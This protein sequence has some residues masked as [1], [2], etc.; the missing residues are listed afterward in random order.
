MKVGISG[1]GG[2]GKTTT[3]GTFAR[4]VGR[5][6]LPVIAIDADSNPNLALTL[7][8]TRQ[9]FDAITPLPHGLMNHKRV[10]GEVHLS[11]SRPVHEVD[12]QFGVACPDNVRLLL[13]GAPGG[14][15]TG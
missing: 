12:E 14:A 8:L 1:K 4:L 11:L 15:G 6:G 5:S 7:G 9:V 13:L 2:S 3:S 10:N